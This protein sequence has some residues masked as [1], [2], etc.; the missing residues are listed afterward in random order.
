MK[1]FSFYSFY[2]LYFL[3]HHIPPPGLG[4]GTKSVGYFTLMREERLAMEFF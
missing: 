3:F 1:F 4:K 2:S